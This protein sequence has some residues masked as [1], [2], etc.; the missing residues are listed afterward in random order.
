MLA[1]SMRS[2]ATAQELQS[3]Y[4]QRDSVAKLNLEE[5]QRAVDAIEAKHMVE[6]NAIR[7]PRYLNSPQKQRAQLI[8]DQLLSFSVLEIRA[9]FSV[10]NHK[11]KT[12]S[13]P[14]PLNPSSNQQ[15]SND[16]SEGIWPAIHPTN[17]SFQ[18]EA[19][20]K[21]MLGSHGFPKEFITKL[22]SGSMFNK[23]DLSGVG[24]ASQTKAPVVEEAK[25][26][27][28]D[29]Y[30][31]GFTPDSKVKLIKELKDMMSLGLKEAKDRLEDAEKNPILLAKRTKPENQEAL[32][33]KMKGLGGL[34]EFVKVS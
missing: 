20:I 15:D 25:E 13:R 12:H 29:F 6:L 21:G 18:E 10:L 19:G 34:V 28:F 1:R 14:D 8:L 4:A 17:L 33:E 32:V 11:E 2:L 24:E 9:I 5:F 31:K 22:V 26:E 30:L 7:K 16:R 27:F 23:I 3:L